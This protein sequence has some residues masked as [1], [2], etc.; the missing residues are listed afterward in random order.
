MPIEAA[1]LDAVER[2]LTAVWST[3]TERQRRLVLG[4]EA[5]ELGWGGV[6]AVARLAG[7]DRSTVS[8][9]V[10]ELDEPVVLEPGRSRRPGGGRK[11][12]TVSDPELAAR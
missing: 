12:L 5:R 7:V 3:L 10:V 2:R 11:P 4:A 8:A 6:S 9:G 1:E